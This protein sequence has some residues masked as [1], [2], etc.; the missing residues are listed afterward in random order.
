MDVRAVVL[1]FLSLAML[2]V[3]GVAVP[4]ANAEEAAEGMIPE[5]QLLEWHNFNEEK[6]GM[7]VNEEWALDIN[8]GGTLIKIAAR[9]S[10]Q[11]QGYATDYQFN[12]HYDINGT[13]YIA[14]L[15]MMAMGVV[16]D[17]QE[18]EIPLATSNDLELS[19]TP[20]VY[21][22]NTPTLWCNISFYNISFYPTVHPE[23]TVDLTLCH[24]VIADWNQTIVKVEAV[25]DLSHTVLFHDHGQGME[26][27]AGTQFAMEVC[28]KMGVGKANSNEGFL[29]P[30]SYSNTSLEYN[31]TTSSGAPLTISSMNME[32]DFSVT[33]HSGSYPST[34]YSYLRL[35]GGAETV[36][37][38]PGL[39]Y[40]DTVS[41]KSDPEITVY[42]DRT[43]LDND[44]G[45]ELPL[46]PALVIAAIVAA[47]L[48]GAL[49]ARKKKWI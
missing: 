36:H 10:T 38:F 27:E 3:A 45:N 9:N 31:L 21:V 16:I 18:M 43:S 11:V 24:H 29:N 32:N 5:P 2:L 17:G 40:K 49:I 42:H 15:M 19:Y 14:Q 37:G 23:S 8:N 1:A 39:I 44:D 41:L 12:I 22:G 47:V 34:A 4:S 35:E 26:F 6:Y 7:L 25:I 30:S 20:F 28:Y 33:N 46:I 13:Q 48:S